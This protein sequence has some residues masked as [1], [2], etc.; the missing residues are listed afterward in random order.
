ML[1]LFGTS[2]FLFLFFGMLR[3]N[4]YRW[5]YLSE[6][7]GAAGSRVLEKRRMQSAVLLGLNGYN[8]LKG[9]V[10]IGRHD[11]GVSFRVMA[12]FSLFHAPLFIPYTDIKGARTRWY[13][14][15]PSTELEFTHAPDVKMIMP[16]EQAEWLQRHAGDV[17]FLNTVD[18]PRAASGWRTFIIACVVFQLVMILV[19]LAYYVTT[20]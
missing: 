5:R 18:P 7:Y 6:N 13:I 11:T 20:R 10:T 4:A 9:I 1:S 17:E 14:D 12:P 19:A 15:G 2:V 3:L 8:S 16:E